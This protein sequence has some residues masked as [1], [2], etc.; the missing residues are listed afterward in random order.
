MYI[1]LDEKTIKKNKKKRRC[2]QRY[3]E[4]RD[5]KKYQQYVIA[6]NQVKELVRKTKMEMEKSIDR[7]AKENPKYVWQYA[8]SKRKTKS[9]IAE[10]KYKDGNGESK[11]T[12]GDK[13][14]AEILAVDFFSSV[15]TKEPDGETPPFNQVHIEKQFED[16]WFGEN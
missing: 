14:K 10:L 2:W 12:D 9:G 11:T 8:N 16:R 4:T 7:N 3:M 13:E 6:R 15:F 5:G 1:P